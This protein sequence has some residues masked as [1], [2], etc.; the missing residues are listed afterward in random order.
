[1]QFRDKDLRRKLTPDYDVGCKRR[2]LSHSYFRAFTKLDAHLKTDGIDHVDVEGDF[3]GPPDARSAGL[4]GLVVVVEFRLRRTR[5]RRG[6]RRASALSVLKK[7]QQDEARALGSRRSDDRLVAVR[8]D[9]SPIR[10]EWYSDEFQRLRQG[11]WST[12]H[13]PQG[14]A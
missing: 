3:V 8:E 7:R 4:V 14:N 12:P 6:S 11:A 13:S 1:V 10:H 5:S 2:T 9:G